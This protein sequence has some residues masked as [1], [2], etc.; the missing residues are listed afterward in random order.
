MYWTRF[1]SISIQ[2]LQEVYLVL[3]MIKSDQHFFCFFFGMLLHL[4]DFKIRTCNLTT[5][6]NS[7]YRKTKLNKPKVSF[8]RYLGM[9]FFNNSGWAWSGDLP[10][11]LI[12]PSFDPKKDPKIYNEKS[13]NI[14]SSQNDE[15]TIFFEGLIFYLWS[16]DS[17]ATP[18]GSKFG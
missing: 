4:L 16:H 6:L 10:K 17:H 12:H 15:S 18:V 8:E 9:I 7:I 11:I 2:G 5:Y 3:V 14:F 13:E 1:F